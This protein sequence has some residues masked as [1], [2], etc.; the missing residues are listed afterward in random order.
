[1]WDWSVECFVAVQHANVS[2]GKLKCWSVECFVA[3][4][5]ADVST[6][7]L[8]A[9]WDWS[10]EWFVVLQHANV[11]TGKLKRW[12][13][14]STLTIHQGCVMAHSHEILTSGAVCLGVLVFPSRQ[15][16]LTMPLAHIE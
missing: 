5:Q 4:Q 14:I 16:V 8:S 9:V 2:T 12:S 1:V 6:G 10:V 3:L 15:V 13:D 11:S 7:K